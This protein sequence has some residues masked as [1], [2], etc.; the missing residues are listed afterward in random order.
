MNVALKHQR[1]HLS[2]SLDILLPLVPLS[3]AAFLKNKF[4]YMFLAPGETKADAQALCLMEM[5]WLGDL[6]IIKHHGY[7]DSP[8]PDLV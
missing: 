5:G 7:P 8:A 6:Y 3:G 2:R 1:D 4:G